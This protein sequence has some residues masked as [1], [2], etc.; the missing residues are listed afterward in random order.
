MSKNEI[1]SGNLKA[2]L[3]RCEYLVNPLGIDVITPRLSWIV[4]SS[5]RAEKQTAYHI[6]VSSSKDLLNE[7][8][9]DLWDSGKVKSD[10][11]L[12]IQYQGKPLESQMYCFW[13]V[14]IWD[15][16]GI[17]SDWSDPAL[18]SMG[19]LSKSDW[20]GKWIG[21]P[22][23]RF[24]F[25]R[26]R[27]IARKK[28]IDPS[29]LLRKTFKTDVKV[30]NAT[31]FATALGEYKLKING[32]PVGNNIFA[33]E[34]TDYNKRLQYQTYDVTE[35]VQTGENVIGAIL[36]DGWYIGNIFPIAGSRVWGND[37]RLL[38]QMVIEFIDGTK[39]EII[40][41]ETW[42]I[43]EDGPIR[44][45]D[46]YLGEIYDAQKEQP[47][48]DRPGFND[49]TWQLAVEDNGIKV[50]LV[51]QMNEPIRIIQELKPISVSEPSPGIFIFNLGQNIAGW[52]RI[53]LNKSICEIGQTIT[54]RHGERL[55]P[56]GTLYTENLRFSKA[57]DK[58]TYTGPEEQIYEPH[59]TYH[60]FQY[61]ELTG[62]KENTKP[63]L[64]ILVACAISSDTPL[65]GTFESSDLS[66]NKLWNNILWTQRDNFITVPTDCP[67]RD[68]RLGWMG[69]AQI[70]A[71]T[72][73][74]NMDLAAFYTKW[75]QDIRD[76]QY[77]DGRYSD[78]CPN[79]CRKIGVFWMG[80]APAWADCGII[81]PWTVY[82]NYADKQL[83]RNHYDSAKQFID[84]VHK[85][86]RNLIWR[87][88]AGGS[89]IT[90]YG[91]WLNGDTMKMEGYPRKGGTI[92]KDVF[93]T[94]Y[95]A[96]STRLLAKMAKVIDL[97]D[98]YNYY[99][100]LA[101]KIQ[102]AFVNKFVSED[103][104]IKGDT[105]STY[106]LALHFDL[107]PEQFQSQACT[108]LMRALE[109]Y[110]GRMSTGFCSTLALILELTR[111][112]YTDKAYSLLLSRRFP[113]WFFTIDQ[114]ATTIWERMD[115]YIP[116]RG[117]QSK[118]M[119]SFNHFAFGAVGE[120]IYRVILG[121]NIDESQPGF[122][123][124]ILKP[125][126]GGSLTW[127]KGSY[128]SIQGL[129][130]IQWQFEDKIFKC[131][132]TIPPNTTATIHLPAK[133]IE[134]IS[135]NGIP[136][137]QLKEIEIIKHVN[138]AVIFKISSGTYSFTSILK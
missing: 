70:F 61:V 75:V 113:S 120:W 91:D 111:R 79:P 71:Q 85:K 60:G 78:F 49:A 66:L 23:R 138:N 124:F 136:I 117:F 24:L 54:L 12:H 57:I 22:K 20:K 101:D 8:K 76:A 129:I 4:E 116:E 62:L 134:A 42:K 95:F 115:S 106:A 125:Q 109:K 81:L 64:N 73:M 35:L 53:H 28:H 123:H 86:N 88:N 105:Q 87:K 3:L 45:A 127:V 74:F 40:S 67:Q 82:L 9:G 89:F 84:F 97:T 99:T 37:R 16:E 48:W 38:F 69:D 92:P 135:E 133:D 122:K 17:A 29:P 118:N 90:N 131:E 102:E 110:E 98:D 34:W 128:R 41:D 52:C 132:V 21:P 39:K 58:F 19:L 31:V 96:N 14:K 2:S 80:N 6:L 103:G 119:T 126:P 121:I 59:F 107:L 55:Y 83:I 33:P 51:A 108:H 114:G 63:D 1:N 100:Q 44:R 56:D 47:N 137:H 5:T 10:Q 25:G 65:V 27:R 11:T 50:N 112:G 46:H 15:K 26:L 104:K 7:N 93:A 94:I 72:S 18:W 77:T 130:A 30:K 13:K 36:A 43:F 68:E 32:K